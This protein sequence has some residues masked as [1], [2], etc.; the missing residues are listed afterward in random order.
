M[1]KA[2][3]DFQKIRPYGNKGDG[4]NDGYFSAEGIYY[5]VYAPKD[6]YEKEAYAAI[7]FKYNFENAKENWDQIS[8]IKEFNFVFNDKGAGLTIELEKA[9]RELKEANKGIEFKIFTP[10]ELERIFFTLGNDQIISLGFDIDSRN[11]IRIA[12]EHLDKLEI[13]LDRE[14]AAFVLKALDNIKNVILDQHDENLSLDYEIMEARAL[15]KTEKI[16]ETREKY[17]NIFKRYPADP[18]APLYLAEI[19]LM[20]EDFEKNK[21]YLKKA[22]QIDGKYWL[23]ELEKLIRNIRLGNQIDISKINE[24]SFPQEPRIKSNYFRLYSLLIEQAGD[25]TKADSFVE[26]AIYLNPDKFINYDT[27]LS[28]LENRIFLHLDDKENLQG[29][30]NILFDEVTAIEQKFAAWLDPGS[31]SKA[32]LNIKKLHLLLIQERY[33]EF[34]KVDKETFDLALK[35]YFDQSIDKIL[36]YSTYYIELPQADLVKLLDYLQNAE[37]PVSYLLAK[38]IIL[39]FIHKNSL[40]TEGKGFFERINKPDI[41]AFINDL[42]NKN[43]E[44]I[45]VF[46]ET[47]ISFAVNLASAK[48]PPELRQKI[49]EKLPNDGIIQKEKLL[50]LLNYDEGN[51]NEAFEI[52]KNL[53]LSKLSYGECIPTLKI[54]KEKKAWDF[55]II[56]LE[57]LLQHEKGI[58]VFQQIKL[59]LFT[60]NNNLERYSEVIRIGEEI[61][62]SPEEMSHLDGFN[63]ETL[64]AQTVVAL[65]KRGEYPKAKEL[66]IKYAQ[67]LRS[68]EVKVHV[69]AEVYLTNNDP[70]NALKSV[71]DAIKIVQRPSPE[72]YGILFLI[73]SKIGNLI[74][75]PLVSLEI[76]GP[77]CFVKLK[78]QERWF[79]IGKENELDATKIT[80]VDENYNSFV[81]N[82]FREKVVFVNKYR[83]NKPEYEIENILPI[84]K[85]ILW[86]SIHNAQKLSLEQRWGVMEM[87]EVPMTEGAIDPK[88]IIARF[89]D[90]YKKREPFFDIYCQKPVPLALLAT[91][92][93]GLTNAIGRIV[94]ERRGFI[95]AS[96]GTL[97]ELNEQKEV[98]RKIIAGQPFYI[99]GTSAFILSETKILEK[100]YQFLPNIKVPQSVISFLL[101]TEEKFRFSPGHVGFMGYASGKINISSV[102]QTKRDVIKSN[103][104]RSIK[105]LE[106]KKENI[107]II[108][109][110]NKLDC[111]SEQKVSPSLSDSCILAQKETIPVLTEDFLY[112]K[113]N[114]L[115]TKKK[116]PEYCSSLSLLRVLYEHKK[117]SFDEYLDFSYYLS[118]YRFR[119]LPIT[120]DD[121]EKAAFGD[122]AFAIVRPEQ[123]RKFNFQLTLSEE[124]GV[125]YQN[126]FLLIGHFLIKILI[127]DSILPNVVEK[128]FAEIISTFPTNKDRKLFGKTLIVASVNAINKINQKL[129]IGSNVQEK[130]DLLCKFIQTWSNNTIIF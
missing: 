47:D 68:F 21:E 64:L 39:Q 30:I 53:D 81:G 22:E 73:L 127:D 119:F 116:A 34:V 130:I 93:G 6:P 102:D 62:S 75:I 5:Q 55:V 24:Q 77:A 43:Y 89:E 13:E 23:L 86:Q 125:S 83:S 18:R 88:Y 121:L 51:V 79:Y 52:L 94:N 117:V 31:R 95:K 84:E 26:K 40:F 107:G 128:I 72:Q 25:Q 27:K 36:V 115:E 85:Y 44:G 2:F 101:E 46:L 87:I 8:A 63:Q 96:T 118:S 58:I 12:Y 29:D 14:N 120:V 112:L 37:K 66:L 19:C 48:V 54:A 76:V 11:T 9:K 45:Q 42:Q 61:L 126:A 97:T 78:D 111:F 98:A 16:K 129:I 15:Q 57:K 28:I 104:E 38:S 110:A 33:S 49:I 114:E 90:D 113:M 50:L 4:G 60:A 106:S 100:I 70:Q 105:L 91:N 124:Y 108:S 1:Q 82:K 3:P 80:E 99:D 7:K 123:L 67:L 92:E 74:D 103:F 69:E 41:L 35:C 109:A 32:L 10:N 65:M 71:V 56:L 59:Q 122:K 20:T 17:Q